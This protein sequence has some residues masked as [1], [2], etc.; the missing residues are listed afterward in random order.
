MEIYV[1]SRGSSRSHEYEWINQSQ[2]EDELSIINRSFSIESDLSHEVRIADFHDLEQPAIIVLR[3]GVNLLILLLT[4]I[5]AGWNAPGG[6]VYHSVAWLSSEEKVIRNLVICALKGELQHNVISAI[7][8]LDSK[9]GFQV[10]FSKLK[11]FDFDKSLSLGEESRS[12][13]TRKLAKNIPEFRHELINEL[14]NI[15]LPEEGNFLIV[16]SDFVS[17]SFLEKVNVWRGLTSRLKQHNWVEFPLKKNSLPSLPIS[18]P[19]QKDPTMQPKLTQ[20]QTRIWDQPKVII[21]GLGLLMIGIL[22]GL[23]IAFAF[24]G[25]KFPSLPTKQPLQENQPLHQSNQNLQE[26]P[27]SLKNQVPVNQQ[28]P[29]RQ[30]HQIEQNQPVPQKTETSEKEFM[31]Q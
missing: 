17:E 28:K 13:E 5:K 26:N 9:P 1:K 11:Q 21:W 30:S 6:A 25:A 8:S 15:C 23:I 20:K 22:V 10:D 2:Q 16:V 3:E 27:L 18:Q 31:S 19:I 4:G 24:L 14:T 29:F 7:T 12:S